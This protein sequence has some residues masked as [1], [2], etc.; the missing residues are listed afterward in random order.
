M[1]NARYTGP[2]AD[3]VVASSSRTPI[4]PREET[5]LE[6]LLYGLYYRDW[7]K[8]RRDSKERFVFGHSTLNELIK[9]AGAG[10][11]KQNTRWPNE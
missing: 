11:K 9:L 10:K 5:R 6:V 1:G 8:M 3:A 7:L 4:A 2:S